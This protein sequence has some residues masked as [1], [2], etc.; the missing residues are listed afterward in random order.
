MIFNDVTEDGSG[1]ESEP[2]S[3]E[4]DD[5]GGEGEEPEGRRGRVREVEWEVPEGF[6]VGNEPD[7]LSSNIDRRQLCLHAVVEKYGWQ[8]G[9]I[10]DMITSA[11][12]RLYSNFNYR[13]TWADGSKV[14]CKLETES[15]SYSAD[16]WLN[17]WVILE[18]A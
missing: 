14:P 10:A 3:G 17:S 2:G 12:P 4:D 7:A 18:A 6:A 9:K 13:V 8:L 11:N 15:Y 5:D 1:S 16:S